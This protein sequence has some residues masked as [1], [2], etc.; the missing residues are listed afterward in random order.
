MAFWSRGGLVKPAAHSPFPWCLHSS[1]CWKYSAS[2]TMH[3]FV[4]V[5]ALL[6]KIMYIV[7]IPFPKHSGCIFHVITFWSHSFSPD[8]RGLGLW[9][10]AFRV[11]AQS[12]VT[13]LKNK[14][15]ISSQQYTLHS[16]AYTHKVVKYTWYEDI[17]YFF[18]PLTLVIWHLAFLHQRVKLLLSYILGFLGMTDESWSFEESTQRSLVI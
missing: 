13:F 11:Y 14:N 7:S 2:L 12:C 5:L 17:L 4:C 6:A 3:S 9:S 8:A 10:F 16:S 18:P 15:S 1:E